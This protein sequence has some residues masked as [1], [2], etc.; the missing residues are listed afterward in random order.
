MKSDIFTKAE[1]H[2]IRELAGMAYERELSTATLA[3]Q[4]NFERWNRREMDVF[5]LEKCIHKF[6]DGASRGLYKHYVMFG[7]AEVLLASAVAREIVKESEVEPAILVKLSSL[8]KTYSQAS[9]PE[10]N[11]EAE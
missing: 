2:R 9:M 8:I 5:E 6:H 3:L 4:K 10:E 1:R 11:K 7:D